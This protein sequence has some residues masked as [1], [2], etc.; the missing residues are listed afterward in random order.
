MFLPA[1]IA[2]LSATNIGAL[3]RP[4][5]YAVWAADS[6]IAR[7]QGNGLDANGNAI[8]SYEHGELQWGLRQLYEK[9]NS[10]TYFDYIQKGIDNVVFSN[11]TVH[12]SYSVASY[13]LDPLRTG[14][15][16][17]YLYE[18]TRLT[19]Y[20]TAADIFRSQLD[21]HPRTAQGQFWH[22]LVY[23]NQGWLD[24]I[25]MGEI[26]YA[27]YT[28][29]FEPTNRTAWDDITQQFVLMFENTIQNATA[30]NNTGLMYHGYD[31]SQVA[32]WASADRGHSPE[33]WDRALGW[34]SMALVDILDI[35]PKSH[36]GHAKILSILQTIVPHIRDAADPTSGVW[37]LVITEPG[38]TKNYF[39]SS[40]AAMFVYAMLKAVRLGHV[41]DSN[42]SISSAAKKAYDYMINNWVVPNS[43]G[44][45]GW[46]NTVIVGSLDTT[47]DFD[48]YTS[49]PIDL[50]DLKGLA[51]FLLASL[52][53]EKI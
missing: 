50:N 6:A 14:P 20:K 16:M 41:E 33:V 52:E 5:S 45:M 49:E 34:Y 8:V 13:V 51:A 22:K 47:G 48:Y 18:E 44:T 36:P 17:I 35:I 4:S 9:T 11:G 29:K 30:P 2:L 32:A 43:D 46:L 37:W 3:A 25:Y 7:G 53:I 21:S 1:I 31:Y 24:G 10:K 38:R 27:D 26:F 19:Q 39:E 42:G 23:P 12:G 15:T 28:S 40:G